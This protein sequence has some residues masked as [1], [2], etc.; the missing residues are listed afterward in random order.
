MCALQGVLNATRDN[1]VPESIE[2]HT[3]LFNP[4]SLWSEHG[5]DRALLTASNTAVLRVDRFF[6][7]EVTQKIF[8]GR[9][10]EDMKPLCGLDL[11]SL[12]IQRGRDHG[13]PAYPVFRKHCNL[14]P[15]DTW[16]EMAN[17]IDANTLQSIRQIYRYAT[18]NTAIK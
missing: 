17:A 15:T 7:Y 5:I 11:V 12:N 14:P 18:E 3:M 16:E 6:S 10:E 9:P 1:S 8:E 13:L 4:F 2:L